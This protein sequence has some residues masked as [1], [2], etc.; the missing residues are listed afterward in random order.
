LPERGGRQSAAH[1]HQ[2][3][4]QSVEQLRTLR[5]AL[6]PVEEVRRSIRHVLFSNTYRRACARWANFFRHPLRHHPAHQVMVTYVR[7]HWHHLTVHYHH[8]GMPHT[9][10]IAERTMGELE[11]RLKTIGS[12]GNVRTAQ[13]YI[14]LLIAYLRAKPYTD[15]R[16][17]RKYCNGLSR[18]ELAGADLPTKDWLKLALKPQ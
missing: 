12:F 4:R 9:N 17:H 3:L 6:K 15:C 2:A 13:A 14:N 18:L 1:I 11:R 7:A 16:G 10:N 8:S 5:Q